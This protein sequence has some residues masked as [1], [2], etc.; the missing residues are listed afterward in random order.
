[1]AS[2]PSKPTNTDRDNNTKRNH[3]NITNTSRIVKTKQASQQQEGTLGDLSTLYVPIRWGNI[4]RLGS[5]RQTWATSTV[6]QLTREVQKTSKELYVKLPNIAK[7]ARVKPTLIPNK[8]CSLGPDPQVRMVRTS[9][10][11]SKARRQQRRY[12]HRTNWQQPEVAAV[13]GHGKY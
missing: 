13:Q 7:K 10:S 4:K 6:N 12:Q 8:A 9:T 3:Q 11:A 2:A 5:I 1:M